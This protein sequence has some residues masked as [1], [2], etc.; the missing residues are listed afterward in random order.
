MFSDHN[1]NYKKQSLT[2]ISKH[3]ETKQ[4]ISKKKNHGK[5]NQKGDQKDFELT[6]NEEHNILKCAKAINTQRKFLALKTYVRK[7]I[8]ASNQWSQLSP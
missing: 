5:R 2:K 6:E 1:G 8:K 3:L 7:R 4:H